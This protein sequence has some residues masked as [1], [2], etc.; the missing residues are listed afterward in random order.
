M[1][2]QVTDYSMYVA[3]EWTSGWSAARMDATS[4]ATGEVIG[5]FPEGRRAA[6]HRPETP[7]TGAG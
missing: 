3:G 6:V 4:P 1:K 2:T 5:T 7:T